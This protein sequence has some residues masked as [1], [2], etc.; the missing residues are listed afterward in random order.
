MF[1]GNQKEQ[2]HE[3]ITNYRPSHPVLADRL[4]KYKT[5]HAWSEKSPQDM[6][7]S[8]WVI[9]TLEVVLWAFFKYSS[10]EE[11]VLAVVNLGED[12]DTAGAIYG[13]L[14][15]A[16]YGFDQIPREWVDGMQRKEF[17]AETANSFAELVFHAAGRVHSE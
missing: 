15:G 1:E 3:T 2:L 7:C 12:S 9:D 8:G 10:W 13:A 6:H 16:F 4:S 11:G 14:A 5:L 17:I